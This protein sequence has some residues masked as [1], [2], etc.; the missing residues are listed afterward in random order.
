MS[1]IQELEKML[2]LLKNQI[3]NFNIDNFNENMGEGKK[4]N[5]FEEFKYKIRF[6]G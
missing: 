3:I 6:F 2:I 4:D 5:I 1:K